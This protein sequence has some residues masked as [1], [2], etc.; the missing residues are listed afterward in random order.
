MEWVFL[1]RLYKQAPVAPG[2]LTQQ[3]SKNVEYSP[4]AKVKVRSET[5]SLTMA[6]LGKLYDPPHPVKISENVSEAL[7]DPAQI[8]EYDDITEELIL[9]QNYNPQLVAVSGISDVIASKDYIYAKKL[10]TLKAR[11][12]N[13][14]EWMFAQ[15]ISTGKISYDDG[16]RK[17]EATFGVSTNNYTLNSSAKIVSDLREMIRTMKKNGHSPAFIVVT[18]NVEKAL[19]D[20][21]Q[22]NKAVDKTSFNVAEMRYE[23]NEPFVNFVTK[24]QGVPP[25][26]VYDGSIGGTSLISGDKIILVDP[27][28]I[29]LAYGA[30]INA[31]LDKNMNPV[32]TDVAS[33]EE[34]T[35]HG[36]QKSLF[37][38]SRPLPYI[39]NANGITINNV[40]VS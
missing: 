7:V 33:W 5:N 25:I 24:I 6:T 9:A 37:V 38:M 40:T 35:N 8:Y 27:S 31:N 3:L 1:T 4:I 16:A 20:N 11:V 2:W 29:F 10:A 36:S 23:T 26:Y 14:L 30:I 19:W 34:I 28:A 15:L 39:L 32:Q 12:K 13:R 22:F 17:Y 18:P 21:T